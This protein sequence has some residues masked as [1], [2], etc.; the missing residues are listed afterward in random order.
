VYS[1]SVFNI[2][3]ESKQ[4]IYLYNS[5][6]NS[7]AEIEEDQ[8]KLYNTAAYEQLDNIQGWLDM[9]F[10]VDARMNEVSALSSIFE[11]CRYE[12]SLGI[13]VAPT[14]LC[15]CAC[16]YCFQDK[17]PITMS[18]EIFNDL[19]DVIVKKTFEFRKPVHIT[20]YGGEPLI[21]HLQIAGFTERLAKLI[22]CDMIHY[23][24]VT[25]GTIY[26]Q[27]TMRTISDNATIDFVQ[28]SLD[29]DEQ[30]HNMSRIYKNG[31]GTY[32]DI[33]KNIPLFLE[34]C[35]IVSL[36]I[37]TTRANKDSIGSLLQDIHTRFGADKRIV[38]YIANITTSNPNVGVQA[39]SCL[40]RQEHENL[41]LELAP[42]MKSFGFDTGGYPQ[43]C[44]G[45]VYT[46]HH[47]FIIDPAGY[48]Y[49]CW[50]YLGF[51][52]FQV[53]HIKDHEKMYGSP[54]FF[55]HMAYNPYHES[56]ICHDCAYLPICVSECPSQRIN[57]F[58]T[59]A[60]QTDCETK[61]LQWRSNVLKKIEELQ[62]MGCEVR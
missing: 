9:G 29:G 58:S 19:T 36:R 41:K 17:T 22:G 47:G 46:S 4:K 40:T 30:H 62:A 28:I 45:C 43:W 21:C 15:N 24:I 8:Y 5:Y 23:S 56:S 49:K 34:H 10:L 1:K 57:P 13:T 27:E 44:R 52:Q 50:D 18:T 59:H 35:N 6:T 32:Q 48:L 20:W 39:D 7:L 38:V 16:P 54:V 33:M 14:L 25:N 2:E 3:I 55:K 37:N 42:L 11:S 51:E 53:G 12:Q 60:K 61:K 26:N 31:E